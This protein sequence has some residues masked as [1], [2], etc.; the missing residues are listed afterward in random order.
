MNMRRWVIWV[1]VILGVWLIASPWLFAAAGG[2]EPAAWN[3]W[4]V[5]G[6]IV[7]LARRMPWRA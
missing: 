7:I 4:C 2:N 5:G 6:G 1:N 3:S